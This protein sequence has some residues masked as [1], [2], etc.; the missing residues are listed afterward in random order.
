MLTF[1]EIDPV[2]IGFGP[3]QLRWYS[4]MYIIGMIAMYSFLRYGSRKGTLK[5]T[6]EQIESL[7]V[8]GL[9]GM[10]LGARLTYVFVY[11]FDHY[12]K[13]PEEIL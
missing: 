6:F 8:H 1:P 9:V 7:M 10:I 11:N 13:H 5:A 4:L 2:I 3:L 12:I